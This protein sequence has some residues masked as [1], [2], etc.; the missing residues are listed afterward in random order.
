VAGAVAA[1][2]EHGVPVVLA[3]DTG[4]LRPLLDDQGAAADIEIVHAAEVI[5]MG[6]T[7]VRMGGLPGTSAAVA[8]GLVA[9]GQR[10]ALRLIALPRAVPSSRQNRSPAVRARTGRSKAIRLIARVACSRRCLVR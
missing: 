7:G 2:S 1:V 5:P 10:S 3:G 8:C 6:D 4:T 9:S